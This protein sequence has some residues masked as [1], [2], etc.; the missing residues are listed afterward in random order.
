MR[1]FDDKI[2]QA[3]RLA[4]KMKKIRPKG[5]F[6]QYQLSTTLQAKMIKVHSAFPEKS[7]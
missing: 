7:P 1:T 6:L 3:Q 5:F 2:P 4:E